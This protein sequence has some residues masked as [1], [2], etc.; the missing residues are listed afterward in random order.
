M[1][2]RNSEYE[3]E[4]N[5]LYQTPPWCT[6]VLI[7]HLPTR[8]LSVWEPAAGEGQMAKALQEAGFDVS[9]SDITSGVDF[10]CTNTEFCYPIF[11]SIITNPPYSEKKAQAFIERAIEL[12]RPVEGVVAMLLRCDYDSGKTRQHLFGEC[13]IFSKKLVLTKR[14]IWFDRPGAAP[15]YNHCWM[16]WDWKH[17]GDPT[18]SYGGPENDNYDYEVKIT[19]KISE[20]KMS[21]I[22]DI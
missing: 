3:R 16:I 6:E 8:V 10:L 5:D 21:R 18:I 1:S 22:M 20:D 14:I 17:K 4:E 11:D 19:T 13:P 9:S 12:T 2:Q 7:P 15:S